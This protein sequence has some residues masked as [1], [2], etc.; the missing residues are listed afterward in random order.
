MILKEDVIRYF[1]RLAPG[2]DAGITPND[3]IISLILDN[4]QVTEGKDILDVG[5]GTGVLIPY[6]LKRNVRSVT[7]VDISPGMT[8][9]ARERFSRPDVSILCGDAAELKTKKRFGSIVIYNAL[10][11]FQDP[12]LLISHLSTLLKHG[13]I[14]TA[15][16]G[17]SREKI[18]SL[19]H[20][21][22]EHIS[23]GLMPA[24]ELA[25]IF[26]KYLKVTVMISDDRMFQVAGI[27][28]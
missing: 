2:W 6:Y 5:C 11:H 3:E 18:N 28:E 21:I 22:T 12:E 19:H 15:A 26:G 10:P 23:G 7:A 9:I 20:G 14:L 16:H 24:D 17:L 25:V 13:G 4:A 27:K 8:A 1:D